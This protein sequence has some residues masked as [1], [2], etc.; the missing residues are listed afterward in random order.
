MP[1]NYSKN[2]ETRE[3]RKRKLIRRAN[4]HGK[5]THNLSYFEETQQNTL[6][7]AAGGNT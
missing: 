5:T 4:E 7:G 1:Y 6:N 2:L 3:A